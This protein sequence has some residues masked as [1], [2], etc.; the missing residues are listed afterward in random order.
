MA[1]RLPL[2]NINKGGPPRGRH[3][4]RNAPAH[5]GVAEAAHGQAVIRAHAPSVAMV[6]LE[7]R[8]PCAHLE[9]QV[10]RGSWAGASTERHS[11]GRSTT[12]HERAHPGARTKGHAES[13]RQGP[14]GAPVT[15]RSCAPHGA[16][17]LASAGV[18]LVG[19]AARGE[20]LTVADCGH[21]PG[22]APGSRVMGAG[23]PGR[24][25]FGALEFFENAAFWGF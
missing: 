8:G 1:W 22:P 15:A 20:P 18:P 23:C 2:H 5:G 19:P 21:H 6:A 11:Y 9:T 16:T 14:R 4:A 12:G 24:V 7:L 10:T 17:D 13:L 25:Y 3:A